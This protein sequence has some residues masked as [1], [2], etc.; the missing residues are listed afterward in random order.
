MVFFFFFV[1]FTLVEHQILITIDSHTREFYGQSNNITRYFYFEFCRLYS[2]FQNIFHVPSNTYIIKDR[3]LDKRKVRKRVLFRLTTRMVVESLIWIFVTNL[4]VIY[5]RIFFKQFLFENEKLIE[6]K[7]VNCI[8]ARLMFFSIFFS[9]F[10]PSWRVYI[11]SC[12]TLCCQIVDRFSRVT[13]LRRILCVL[14]LMRAYCHLSHEI[15][16][17]QILDWS[18]D[19]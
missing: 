16:N 8:F 11:H 4:L 9:S 19:R 1:T 5:V 17:W 13:I 18:F 10:C 12:K 14:R 7:S 2:I 6:I 3:R 15:Y